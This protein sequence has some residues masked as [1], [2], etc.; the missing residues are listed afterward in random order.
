[1]VLKMFK[2]LVYLSELLLANPLV[3]SLMSEWITYNLFGF[4]SGSDFDE[5]LHK[6]VRVL[7]IR[8]CC[9]D[10]LIPFECKL[11]ITTSEKLLHFLNKQ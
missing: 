8:N 2:T 6:T 11:L 7:M 10:Y 5:R 4:D 1:M 9:D 3:V